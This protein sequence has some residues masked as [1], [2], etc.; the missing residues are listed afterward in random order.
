MKRYKEIMRRA[1]EG[2][3]TLGVVFVCIFL[4]QVTASSMMHLLAL[5]LMIYVPMFVYRKVR[6]THFASYGATTFSWLWLEG[7]ML[8]LH[9]GIILSLG[10]LVFM[11]WLV[12][13]YLPTMIAQFRL[14]AE[15]NP[16]FFKSAGGAEQFLAMF[17][18]IRPIDIAITL[19]WPV[20]LSGCIASL[21]IA[22][23]TKSKQVP[24]PALPNM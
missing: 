11:E 10:V 22:A 21:V 7:L 24:P 9:G 18:G 2:G 12:P 4:L 23:V 15:S 13:E 17:N 16:G 1:A 5:G 6:T 8:F 19:L 3:I 14:F 20:M